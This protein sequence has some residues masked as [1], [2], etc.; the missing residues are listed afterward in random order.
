MGRILLLFRVFRDGFNPSVLLSALLGCIAGKRLGETVTF[1]CD[2][3]G[4]NIEFFYQYLLY[5]FRAA[6]G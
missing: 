5:R 4:I 2:P 1:R 6:L 3:G